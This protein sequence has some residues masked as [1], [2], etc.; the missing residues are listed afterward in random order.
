MNL[1]HFIHTILINLTIGPT[2]TKKFWHDWFLLVM[3]LK[4]QFDRD[5]LEIAFSEDG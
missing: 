3:L 1:Q 2:S 5:Y 4:L